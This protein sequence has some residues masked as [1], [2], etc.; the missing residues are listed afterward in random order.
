MTN[1]IMRL[2]MRTPDFANASDDHYQT[3]LNMVEWADQQG[4][5][6][7]MLSEHHGCED[8]YLPSPLVFA[9]AIAAR[10][11]RLRIRV[12]ALVLPL[13]D[14]LRVAEDVAIVDH[15][16]GGRIE[17]VVVAGFRPCEF[18]MFD[19]PYNRRGKLLEEGIEVL[20]KAWSGESFEYRGAK[21]RVT[22]KTIQQPGP[23]ILLGGSSEIAARRAARLAQGFVPAVAQLYPIYLDECE[24]LGV[25]PGEARNIGPG[26]I[27]VSHDPEALW[28]KLAPH[29]LHETNGYSKWYAETGT[30]GPYQPIEDANVLRESGLYHVVTPEQCI[31]LC[32][33]LGDNGWMFVHP[34]LSGLDP[35]LGWQ[36][37]KLLAEEVIPVLGEGHD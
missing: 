7:C 35:E 19:K 24:K 18:A 6:E 2:D 4:F 17:L 22:P 34:L 8:N 16:S 37:L 3:A 26:S 10:T 33:E 14:P 20:K 12:S 5:V 27:F 21:V 28:E 30:A 11:K 9:G 1:F 25:E 13:H 15:I 31:A 29:A 23:P 36:S 32:Q